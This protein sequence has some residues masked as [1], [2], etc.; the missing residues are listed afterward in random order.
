M[1]KFGRLTMDDWGPIMPV[2]RPLSPR[3]PWY[4]R[5]TEA[6]VV[7]Y[8]TDEDAV[9]DILPEDLELIEPATAFAVLETN[10]KTTVGPYSEVY[11]AIMCKWKDEVMAYTNAV[12]VTGEKSQILGREIWG[13]GK[14][15][16][17]NIELIRHD[18]GQVEAVLEV[19]PGNVA[20][21]VMAHPAVRESAD[22]VE[23]IPL[24]V[25]KVR[26]DAEGGPKPTL[27][28]L[29]SVLFEAVPHV[30]ADGNAEV[31]SGSATVELGV[32]SDVNLPVKEVLSCQ[33]STFYADLPY[34]RVLKTYA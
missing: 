21:R 29:V 17:H 31:Y 32:D 5:E 19:V 23:S 9:L 27:A 14:K 12:Y 4:Y 25:L 18:T 16:A 10:H 15:R 6:L 3:G 26:P 8:L 1:A 20:M 11:T 2:H 13:F 34:G 7:T 28:Q 33:Y 22:A 30:G 24:V